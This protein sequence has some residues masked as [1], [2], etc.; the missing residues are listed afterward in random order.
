MA[1][2]LEFLRLYGWTISIVLQLVVYFFIL[3]LRDKFAPKELEVRVVAQERALT[4]AVNTMDKRLMHVE[5]T[6][7]SLPSASDFGDLKLK[8]ADLSGEL[9]RA[10]EASDGLENLIK[11]LERQVSLIDQSLRNKP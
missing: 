6:M 10:N 1:G 11:R 8:M 5:I 9:K 7:E 2:A 3:W 4:E